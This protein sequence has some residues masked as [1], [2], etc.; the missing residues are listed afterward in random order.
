MTIETIVILLLTTWVLLGW[1]GATILTIWDYD[2]GEAIAVRDLLNLV[3][4]GA[5]FGLIVF[6]YMLIQI[7]N[8]SSISSRLKKFMTK[9]IWKKKEEK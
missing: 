1:F 3:L 9:P 5:L 7:W 2:N 4:L 6:V 8:R